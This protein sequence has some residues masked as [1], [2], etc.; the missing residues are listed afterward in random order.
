M[1][2]AGCY[3]DFHIDMG[4]TSV[5]YHILRGEK[6]FWLAP[7]TEANFRIYEKWTL[8][9]SQSCS[10]LGDLVEQCQRVVLRAGSTF[11]M[12][13]GWIHSV[14]TSKDSLVFGGNFLHSYNVPM[15]L[16][17]SK[18]E[19]KT[20]VPQKYRYPFFNEIMW[21]VL[22]RFVALIDFIFVYRSV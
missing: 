6:I 10:F 19:Q 16:K 2:V 9:G 18:T 13:S 8:S 1:S 12:P 3:T 21:F 20:R 15:Q 17:V 4:G 14:Y 5:W 7:P 22:E 11:L